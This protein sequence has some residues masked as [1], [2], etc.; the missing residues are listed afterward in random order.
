MNYNVYI[1]IS[2]KDNQF[3]TGYSANL[4]NRIAYHK[5]GLVKSTVNRRPLKLLFYEVYNN[6]IDAQRRE[7]YFKTNEGKKTL[8]LMLRQTLKNHK[9]VKS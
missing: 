9:N 3:Y 7:K 5:K 8:K 4:H 6:K 1:L 2:L